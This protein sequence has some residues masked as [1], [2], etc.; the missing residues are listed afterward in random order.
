VT[1]YVPTIL[2]LVLAALYWLAA[3]RAKETASRAARNRCQQHGVLF[4]DDTVA[5]R[6]VRLRRDDRSAV[7]LQREYN[8]EFAT[9][10]GRRYRGR[11]LLL[12]ARVER[13]DLD[14]YD[15]EP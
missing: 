13:V 15:W 10:G 7:H 3:A 14:A 6:R 12:G 4:L 5:L 8:F 2:V 11:V 9:D 1:D